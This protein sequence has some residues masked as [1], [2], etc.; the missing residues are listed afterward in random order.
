MIDQAV[1]FL[2]GATMMADLGIAVGFFRYWK[3]TDDRLFIF[4]SCAFGI[5]AVSQIVVSVA[6]DT[7]EFAPYA[8]FMRLIAF[9][10]IVLG[11]LDKNLP[12]GKT[13]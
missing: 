12:T 13:S 3:R 5:L 9:I 6:G 2:R 7:G 4:F 11:I 10:V 8:Y 1:E